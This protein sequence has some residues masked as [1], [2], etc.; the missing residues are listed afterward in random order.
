M[1]QMIQKVEKS[2]ELHRDALETAKGV[3]K[4]QGIKKITKL[5]EMDAISN[6]QRYDLL[7]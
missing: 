2:I 6:N 3:K 5:L 7:M 1:I 4:K